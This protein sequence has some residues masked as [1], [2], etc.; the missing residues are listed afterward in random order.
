[1]IDNNRPEFLTSLYRQYCQYL[2]KVSVDM[3]VTVTHSTAKTV[4][5]KIVKQFGDKVNLEIMCEKQ[6]LV[7]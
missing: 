5:D 2:D 1:M 6:G 4:G 7:L 3:G